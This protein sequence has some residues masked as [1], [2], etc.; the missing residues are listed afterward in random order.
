MEGEINELTNENEN[1]NNEIFD[2]IK[3]IENN[4]NNIKRYNEYM[5]IKTDYDAIKKNIINLKNQQDTINESLKKLLNHKYN[6]NCKECLSHPETQYKINYEKSLDDIINK[7][8]E[9]DEDLEAKTIELNKFK[10]IFNFKIDEINQ[11]RNKNCDLENKIILIN[12][13]LKNKKKMLEQTINEI[14]KYNEEKKRIEENNNLDIKI[15]SIDDQI[16]KIIKTKCKKHEDYIS[17]TKIVNDEKNNLK[18]YENN[19]KEKQ[20]QIKELDEQINTN[21]KKLNEYNENKDKIQEKEDNNNKIGKLKIKTSNNENKIKQLEKDDLELQTKI[22]K[23]KILYEQEDKQIEEYKTKMNEIKILDLIYDALGKE[24]IVNKLLEDDI[25]PKL[26]K[27][28]NNVLEF[29]CEYKI[30][31]KSNGNGVTLEKLDQDGNIITVYSGAEAFIFHL[32]SKL[33]FAQINNIKT[34]FLFIDEAFVYCGQEYDENIGNILEYIKNNFQFCIVISHQKNIID[35]YTTKIKIENEDGF[36]K[37][38]Y[39]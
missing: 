2:N 26:E 28:I 15:I 39:E 7:I 25:L 34:N 10:D 14:N 22:I 4:N 23:N 12:K 16:K 35:R 9:L 32:A 13:E 30:K 33:S 3:F 20:L 5:T 37:I 21:N 24:G 36:S 29:I 38:K 11:T 8:N 17:K 18:I 6:K 19:L 27:S 1:I 31:L